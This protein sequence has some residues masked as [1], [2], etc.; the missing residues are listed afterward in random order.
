MKNHI[1]TIDGVI[2][3][4]KCKT[5][6]EGLHGKEATYFQ[7]RYE[8]YTGLEE[9]ECSMFLDQ[10]I[11]GWTQKH[12]AEY[13]KKY[14]V[15]YEREYR[16]YCSDV[17]VQKKGGYSENHYDDTHLGEDYVGRTRDLTVLVYLND[18][19]S[20]GEL[21]FQEQGSIVKPKTG[22]MVIF[23]AGITHPHLT[24]PCS[25]DRYVIVVKYVREGKRKRHEV[26]RKND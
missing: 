20:G 19:K 22:R 12:F 7:K 21:V 1:Q 2:P 24:L 23:P 16:Y 5:I 11:L 13:L 9:Y 10:Y 14:G 3:P 18:V 4:E 17:L 26:L 6:I 15:E 8:K 25:D